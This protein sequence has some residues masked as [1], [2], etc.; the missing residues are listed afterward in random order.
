[1]SKSSIDQVEADISRIEPKEILVD[2]E[3]HEIHEI[4]EV[5]V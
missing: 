2:H 3:I 4:H 5:L 1:M